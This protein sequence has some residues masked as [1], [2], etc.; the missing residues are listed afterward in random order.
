MITV[1]QLNRLRYLKLE[2][3]AE[4]KR[5]ESIAPMLE[6][7]G[8]SYTT[9]KVQGGGG[10]DTFARYVSE[11]TYLKQLIAENM[12]RCICELLRLEEF[13][14]TIEEP[15]IRIIF[16]ERYMKC[17]SWQSIA[18]LLDLRDEQIPRRRHDR[19]LD[20]YNKTHK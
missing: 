19:Y 1:Q 14:R 7:R 18:T 12:K 3:T 20:K 9:E 15:D 10:G 16:K 5:L 4:K 11:M 6:A 13:I 17:R 8:V 2:I